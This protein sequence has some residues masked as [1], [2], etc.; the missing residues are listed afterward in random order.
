M[1]NSPLILVAEDDPGAVALLQRAFSL[2]G[3]PICFVQDGED[4]RR[5][6]RVSKSSGLS[7]AMATVAG[8]ENAAKK[9][10]R[11]N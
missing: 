5:K 9:W 10:I 3:N 1:I 2:V 4:A 6:G 7:A 11:S 8:S